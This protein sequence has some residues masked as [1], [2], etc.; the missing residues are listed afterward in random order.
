M[1]YKANP[2]ASTTV[3]A[4]RPVAVYTEVP[5]TEKTT[6]PR[7]KVEKRF[8]LVPMVKKH[9]PVAV[10]E[11]MAQI[12]REGG[13]KGGRKGLAALSPEDRERIREKALKARRA[14][15]PPK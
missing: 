12:G 4:F 6:I 11:Y 3:R 5:V 10:S 15:K 1:H 9:V 14:E 7:G 2:T 13:K 8:I